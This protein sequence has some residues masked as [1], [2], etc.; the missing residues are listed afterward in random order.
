MRGGWQKLNPASVDDASMAGPTKLSGLQGGEYQNAHVN[1][2]GG[3]AAPLMVDAPVG[4][5]GLLPDDMRQIARVTPIDQSISAIR[6]MSDQSGGA[7]R[8]SRRKR[9]SR[10]RYTKK[11]GGGR[12]RYRKHGGGEMP[13]MGTSLDEAD[14][15]DETAA[16]APLLGGGRRRRSRR[17]KSRRSRRR[18]MYGGQFLQ[19]AAVDMPGKLLGGG[20]RRGRKQRGGM[21]AMM[22]AS[23][24]APGM[25]MPDS[26]TV[27]GMNPEWHLAKDPTSFIPN[28]IKASIAAV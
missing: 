10:G 26:Q 5:Q 19:P 2:H 3:A 12:R 18:T 25:I 21:A 24:D 4:D 7:R 20:R 22:P 28:T 15:D 8:R 1:Q 13:N 23:A 6:G 27:G 11:N 9:N 14:D 16:P 17:S